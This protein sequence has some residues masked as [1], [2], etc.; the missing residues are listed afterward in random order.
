MAAGDV[1]DVAAFFHGGELLGAEH[2]F[3][4]GGGG[5]GEDDDVGL[6]EDFFELVDAVHGIG[7]GA[8]GIAEV[9]FH[10][11]GFCQLGRGAFDGEDVHAEGFYEASD[12]AADGA[13]ADDANGTATEL[14][15]GEDVFALGDPVFVHLGAVRFGEAA[16]EAQDTGEDIFGD[17]G[18]VDAGGGGHRNA[19]V[20]EWIAVE[21]V[22]AG[23]E[24]L[25]PFEIRGEVH[26]VFRDAERVENFGGVV[27]EL[28]EFR[29]G[30]FLGLADLDFGREG[31][32]A[33]GL[34]GFQGGGGYEVH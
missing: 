16:V 2:A 28:I 33:F 25:D 17:G 12:F 30:E 21:V 13:V 34:V 23:A 10:V 26:D 8:V 22:A 31:C 4:F 15:G 14:A 1:D 11:A 24:K 5:H 3:G 32:E 9:G 27:E 7:N 19:S 18:G 29:V 6:G 20:D